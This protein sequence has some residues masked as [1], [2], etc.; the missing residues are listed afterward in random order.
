LI[1]RW[2]IGNSLSHSRIRRW[3]VPHIDTLRWK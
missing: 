1:L 2:R 3:A